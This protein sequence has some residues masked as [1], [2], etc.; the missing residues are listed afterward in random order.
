[1]KPSLKSTFGAMFDSLGYHLIANERMATA[2]A[3]THLATLFATLRIDLVVDIGADSG[4]F[5]RFLRDDVGYSGRIA[6][7]EAVPAN[8]TV[9]KAQAGP[10][11]LWDVEHTALGATG[12]ELP[13]NVIEL[14]SVRA[15]ASVVPTTLGRFSRQTAR[16]RRETV[17]VRTLDEALSHLLV[18]HGAN[19][20]FLKLNA[21]FRDRDVLKGAE[22]SLGKIA[23]LQTE[24]STTRK[25]EGMPH[26]LAMLSYFEAKHFSPSRFFP[27]PPHTAA[28][29]N[30]FECCMVNAAYV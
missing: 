4:Q 18:R 20:V 5:G 14:Q 24:L 10:D 26:Y 7:F 28:A 12:G 25:S 19:R 21:R 3:A 22:K 29:P 2:D 13:L 27:I 30:G 23:A 11:E 9:L 16:V 17:P 15:V 1:M 6:S 8:F